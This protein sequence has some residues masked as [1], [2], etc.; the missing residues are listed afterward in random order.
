MSMIGL[1]AA[2]SFFIGSSYLAQMPSFATDLG[3]L[4]ADFLYSMLLSADAAGA[5]CAGLI[6]ESRGLLRAQPRTAIILAM[7]WSCALA[8]FALIRVYPIALVVLFIA[9]FVELAFS[10][11]A[12]T[13]VQLNAPAAIRGRVIG[14]YSMSNLGL[15]TFSGLTI[16]FLGSLI[17]VRVALAAS[18]A[19]LFVVVT[20]LFIFRGS[21]S[22]TA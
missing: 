22:S 7:I 10:A 21:Q 6:L 12:Q 16:G 1:S 8:A 5:L 15:R 17:G 14:V 11:M 13:L 19:V 9:G 20:V 18:A 3:R 4:K 2:A